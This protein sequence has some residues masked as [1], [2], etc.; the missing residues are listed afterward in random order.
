MYDLPEIEIAKIPF[1]ESAAGKQFA[2][3]QKLRDEFNNY[4]AEEAAYHAAETTRQKIAERRGFI[5]GSISTIVCGIVVAIFAYF[6]P[7]IVFF[8][9]H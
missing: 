2:E 7:T 3:L 6:W 5:F 8:F 1:G 9:S 4:R